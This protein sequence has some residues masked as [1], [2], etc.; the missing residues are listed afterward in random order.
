MYLRINSKHIYLRSSRE[1]Q[2]SLLICVLHLLLLLAWGEARVVAALAARLPPRHVPDL[3]QAVGEEVQVRHHPEN[4][5]GS[6][7]EI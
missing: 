2:G 6:T 1:Q 5:Y 3:G 7:A 4:T